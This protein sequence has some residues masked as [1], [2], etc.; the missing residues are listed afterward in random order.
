MIALGKK[1]ELNQMAKIQSEV[2]LLKELK[3]LS[4]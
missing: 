1:L 2:E 3:E 4:L